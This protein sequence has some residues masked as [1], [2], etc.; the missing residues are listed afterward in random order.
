V[1]DFLTALWIFVIKCYMQQFWL[2][3]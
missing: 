2:F 1:Q 3:C